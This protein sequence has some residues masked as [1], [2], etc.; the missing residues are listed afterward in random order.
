MAEVYQFEVKL[1]GFEDKISRTIEVSSLS[2]LSKFGFTNI[3]AFDG[4]GSHLFCVIASNKQYCIYLDNTETL[5]ARTATLNDLNLKMGEQITIIYDFGSEWRF[6]AVLK[7]VTEMGR[8]KGRR[9]PLVIDGYGCGII[10]N[11]FPPQLEEIIESV[12]KTGE[13]YKL[14]DFE[15]EEEYFYDPKYFCIDTLNMFLKDKVLEMEYSCNFEI[16]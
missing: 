13:N 8:G 12:T 11:F 4:D 14:F 15:T 10:E 7:S 3:V 5:D 16:N 1:H 2:T 6:D 9:Y